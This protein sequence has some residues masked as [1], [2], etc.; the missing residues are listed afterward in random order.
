MVLPSDQ[1]SPIS[2]TRNGARPTLS[3]IA[4]ATLVETAEESQAPESSGQHNGINGIST[5]TEVRE[6]AEETQTQTQ[7]Q[8]PEHP[9]G[10]TPTPS[11]ANLMTSENDNVRPATSLLTPLS[12]SSTDVHLLGQLTIHS[13]GSNSNSSTHD[14]IKRLTQSF[15]TPEIGVTYVMEIGL[16]PRSGSVKEAFKHVWGGGLVEVVLGARTV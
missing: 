5:L 12:L 1:P 14:Y 11:N 3:G 13:P 10:D 4:S 7:T 2:P 15:M 8:A 16:Q 6:V 9:N